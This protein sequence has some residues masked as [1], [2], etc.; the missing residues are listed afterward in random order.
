MGLFIR[1]RIPVFVQFEQMY[2]QLRQSV[3]MQGYVC[4]PLTPI[5]LE[6]LLEKPFLIGDFFVV[7]RLIIAMG[8][9]CSAGLK[10]SHSSAR[11][12]FPLAGFG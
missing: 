10:Y 2:D 7:K 6:W 8:Y 11:L 3:G 9:L 5:Y 4:W 12:T 1:L